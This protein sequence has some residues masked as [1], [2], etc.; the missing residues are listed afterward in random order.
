MKKHTKVY[1]DAFGYGEGDFIPSEVSGDPAVDIHH[2]RAKGMGGSKEMDFIENLMALTR[3]E[4]DR[5]G[6]KSEFMEMLMWN[7]LRFLDFNGVQWD[8]KNVEKVI[9]NFFKTKRL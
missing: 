8:P 5:W 7:H 3:D 4:H 6:D 9:P 1:F 2:I